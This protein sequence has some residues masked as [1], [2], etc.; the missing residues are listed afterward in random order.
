MQS[1]MLTPPLSASPG[2][3]RNC[4]T[5]HTAV[6]VPLHSILQ[7]AWPA[8]FHS[9]RFACAQFQVQNI[10]SSLL[11]EALPGCN[12]K[13][14]NS[15]PL[16][17]PLLVLSLFWSFSDML[18]E[19]YLAERGW[20]QQTSASSEETKRIWKW[21][22]GASHLTV[23]NDKPSLSQRSSKTLQSKESTANSSAQP[24]MPK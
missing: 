8:R 18:R 10:R 3:H 24:C 11:N 7:S 5:R 12:C 16:G 15:A 13:S 9:V 1:G 6:L 17:H 22:F 21:P 23:R 20:L 14:R 2:W 19:M 4:Y